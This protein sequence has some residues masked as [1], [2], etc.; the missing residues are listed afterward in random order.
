MDSRGDKLARFVDLTIPAGEAAAEAKH[1]IMRTQE[2]SRR[3]DARKLIIGQEGMICE[4]PY[5]TWQP[6]DDTQAE[7]RLIDDV[8]DKQVVDIGN[9]K[10]IRVN[11]IVLEYQPGRV[12]IKA[13][14][15]GTTSFLRR[16]GGERLAGTSRSILHNQEITIDWQHVMPLGSASSALRLSTPWEKA[17]AFHPADLAL[18]MEDLDSNEQIAMLSNLDLEKA[19]ETLASIE[20]DHLRAAIL[21]RLDPGR[22]SDIVE[23]MS[24]DDAADFLADLPGPSADAILDSME[25][26]SSDSVRHLMEYD[27]RTAGG[28]MTTEYVA[29]P[30]DI[31][32]DQAIKRIRAIA[33]EAEEIYYVYVVDAENHLIG[34]LSL[35]ELIVSREDERL[36]AIMM[37]PVIHAEARWGD[38]ECADM[39]A[40][41]DF[42]SLPVTDEKKHLL[43]IITI[44]DVIDLVME[45]GGWRRRLR[46]RRA[47]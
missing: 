15:V 17:R 10:I 11:D 41:Y 24:P 31:T 36:G 3:A 44:D 22:A 38:H 20:E 6:L 12:L 26:P 18:L 4:Q 30:P 32:V 21:R 43:G 40:R 2:G 29:L 42:I 34:V 1:V 14:C 16:L 23:E 8:M 9:R 47:T 5:D 7:V 27:E 25:K 45:R 28:M 13:V 37:R 35:R 33:Q 39:M 19:A 46:R